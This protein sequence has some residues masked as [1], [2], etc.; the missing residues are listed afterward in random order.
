M[1]VFLSNVV[2]RMIERVRI[3]GELAEFV[4]IH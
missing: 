4:A 2:S 3:F 1:T